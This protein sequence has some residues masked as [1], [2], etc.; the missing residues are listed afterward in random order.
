[1][2][3]KL[4]VLLMVFGLLAAG[5]SFALRQPQVA[6]RVALLQGKTIYPTIEPTPGVTGAETV[7]HEFTFE[8]RTYRIGASIDNAVYAGSKAGSRSAVR[9]GEFAD[10]DWVPDYYRSFVDEPHMAP[11]YDAVLAEARPMRDRDKLDGDRYVEMLAALVQT[12]PYRI[13]PTDAAPRFPVQTWADGGDCDDKA[14]L[15]AG[16]LTREG[17][18]VALLFFEPEEHV[19]LGVRAVG[20]P[21]YR[22]TGYVYLETTKPLLVGLP[23]DKL[24]DGQSLRSAPRVIR[25]GTGKTGFSAHAEVRRIDR[26][27]K[28]ARAQRGTLDAQVKASRERIGELERELG[29]M[30]A[31]LDSLAAAGDAATWQTEVSAFNA[32]YAEYQE[33]H[34]KD[35]ELVKAYNATVELERRVAQGQTDRSGLYRYLK[36]QR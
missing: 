4:L 26:A 10:D 19:A 8:G 36:G 21:G 34:R 17:Y 27:L 29:Q 11:L 13:D 35:Q 15:L 18:D 24:A 14:L 1:M 7:A 9:L 6:E 23:P 32:R 16:L 25:I 2:I 30:R 28:D 20:E 3:R 22:D 31:R 12:I 5:G 33:I